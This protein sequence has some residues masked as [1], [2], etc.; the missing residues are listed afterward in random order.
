MLDGDTI[1]TMGTNKIQSDINLVGTLAS[2]VMSLAIS[3]GIKN[4]KGY[5]DL[6]SFQDIQKTIE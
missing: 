6:Y 3:N 5:R 2:E 1:F 4:T